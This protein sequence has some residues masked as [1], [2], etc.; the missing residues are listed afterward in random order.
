MK[1]KRPS[2]SQTTTSLPPQIRVPFA[3][4]RGSAR[5]ARRRAAGRGCRSAGAPARVA[6]SSRVSRARGSSYASYSRFLGRGG[7]N[8]SDQKAVV[9]ER[10]ASAAISSRYCYNRHSG[11]QGRGSTVGSLKKRK[12]GALRTWFFNA[13][14][15]PQQ[16][17][18]GLL[19]TSRWPQSHPLFAHHQLRRTGTLLVG[20]CKLVLSVC[21]SSLSAV[22]SACLC[23]TN[24]PYNFI[25]NLVSPP[26]PT[27][28]T[29]SLR[30]N[31]CWA[32]AK[33]SVVGRG[34]PNLELAYPGWSE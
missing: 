6:A 32:P 7:L 10:R 17:G 5:A 1:F 13:R 8:E 31:P 9:V 15:W 18:G 3:L 19:L 23:L 24:E 28:K 34:S 2:G 20:H 11:R 30:E 14:E 33:G 16:E 12:E 26:V 22:E 29:L 4:G 27:P 25:M 21:S